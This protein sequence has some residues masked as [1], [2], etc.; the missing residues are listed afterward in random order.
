M[1]IIILY[2]DVYVSYLYYI[3]YSVYLIYIV[4]YIVLYYTEL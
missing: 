3:S 1:K 4:C 2:D